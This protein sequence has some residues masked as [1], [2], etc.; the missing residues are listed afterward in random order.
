[1]GSAQSLYIIYYILYIIYYILYIIY[2]IFGHQRYILYYYLDP[3]GLQERLL[4]AAAD[5]GFAALACSPGRSRQVYF[6]ML[7]CSSSNNNK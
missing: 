4:V 7:W 5:E 1:M 2:Y 6:I 3:L